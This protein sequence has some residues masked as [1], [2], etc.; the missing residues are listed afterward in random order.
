[1]TAQQLTWIKQRQKEYRELF[2]EELLLNLQ[3][4]NGVRVPA[5]IPNYNEPK[6]LNWIETETEKRG[7]DLDYVKNHHVHGRYYPIEKKFLEDYATFLVKNNFNL[8]KAARLIGKSRR[9]MGYLL[10][11]AR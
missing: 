6:I 3:A 4:M 8:T 1:M 11:N 7:V 5:N 9:T 2:G 10:D